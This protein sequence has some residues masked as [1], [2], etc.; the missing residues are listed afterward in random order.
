MMSRGERETWL[1]GLL[2]RMPPRGQSI[3]ASSVAAGW[4][5]VHAVI[6]DGPIEGSFDYSAPF[7]TVVFVLK[8]V[9]QLEWRRGQRFSRLAARAGDVLIT[10][11]G[12]SNGLRTNLPIEALWC[13]IG[14][15]LLE[16][17]E[18][19]GMAAA[20]S[21]LGSRGELQSQ[22]RGSVGPGPAARR[23]APDSDQGLP[24]LCGDAPD[25]DRHPSPLELLVAA[26]GGGGRRR[27]GGSSA[28]PGDRIHPGKPGR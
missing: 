27:P 13:L 19:R 11:R 26:P 5:G 15:D 8:G 12:D 9:A 18:Q 2:S 20:R 3:V 4:D 23:A 14:Q 25:P 24:A 6:V 7:P 28:A 21:S 17:I 22:R 1:Q 10:P 16:R